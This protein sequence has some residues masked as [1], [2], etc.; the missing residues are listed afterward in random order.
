M[1]T[2]DPMFDPLRRL[3][4]QSA[5]GDPATLR[6]LGDR[7]RVRRR[8]SL[9]AVAVVVVLATG[10]GTLVSQLNQGAVPAPV[11]PSPT[12]PATPAPSPVATPD[13]SPSGAGEAGIPDASLPQLEDFVWG[14]G[15]EFSDRRVTDGQGQ[16][17]VSSCQ[18]E[19]LDALGAA[20][21]RV[22]TVESGVGGVAGVLGFD[23]TEDAD[24]AWSTLLRWADDCQD[25][26]DQ[27]DRGMEVL[28]DVPLQPAGQEGRFLLL[29]EPDR[30]GLGPEVGGFEEVGLVRAG[31]R[32]A[33]VS[34]TSAA[35]EHHFALEED[36]GTGMPLDPMIRT[37]DNIGAR[38]A[39]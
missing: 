35:P 29:V 6:Q 34:F 24:T 33:L 12:A 37:L 4:A 1:S 8:Q 11:A 9:G 38:L 26:L 21:V 2:P 39:P 30:D 13:P 16:A 20:E 27:Q 17:A 36:D 15:V 5:A 22:V 32:M 31:D 18:Q 25:Q 3:S 28:T 7:R 19:E 14:P 10:A 23:S